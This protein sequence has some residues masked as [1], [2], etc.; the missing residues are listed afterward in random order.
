MGFFDRLINTIKQDLKGGSAGLRENLIPSPRTR[1]IDDFIKVGRSADHDQ[2]NNAHNL[3]AQVAQS[4]RKMDFEN[5]SFQFQDVP[6]PKPGQFYT[7]TLRNIGRKVRGRDIVRNTVIGLFDPG[8]TSGDTFRLLDR[9]T[10]FLATADVGSDRHQELL[11]AFASQGIDVEDPNGV[12]NFIFLNA[13]TLTRDSAAKVHTTFGHEVT[14]AISADAGLSY[15]YPPADIL[16]LQKRREAAMSAFHLAQDEHHSERMAYRIANAE[17]SSREMR[18][19]IPI[20]KTLPIDSPIIKEVVDSH[21]ALYVAQFAAEEARAQ[22]GGISLTN[23]SGLEDQLTGEGSDM[24]TGYSS[25]GGFASL[26]PA[27]QFDT[28]MTDLFAMQKS[29]FISGTTEEDL[30][31]TAMGWRKS[32]FQ[33]ASAVYSASISPTGGPDQVLQSAALRQSTQLYILSSEQAGISSQLEGVKAG[34]SIK[35]ST[36]G[37]LDIGLTKRFEEAEKGLT[38]IELGIPSS[39]LLQ[40]TR[41][42]AASGAGTGAIQGVIG[43]SAEG[44]IAK[45][46]AS[47]GAPV[48]RVAG[49]VGVMGKKTLSM[50]INAGETAARVMR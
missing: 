38:Q 30:W 13:E 35:G 37:Q 7:P 18:R 8:L 32:I 34:D 12:T 6:Q 28:F 50:L 23:L 48:Q 9:A 26:Y 39:P 15:R 40:I 21:R 42:A 20:P 17:A 4:F 44:G 43:S 31:Q 45:S 10:G 11:K 29:G 46:I 16:E 2:P 3:A 19:N 27:E 1:T 22:T 49:K 5:L 14:H 24:L 41:E 25:A 36:V 33:D 47:H